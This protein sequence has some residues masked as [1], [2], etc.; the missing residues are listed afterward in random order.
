VFLD[1]WPQVGTLVLLAESSN[2]DITEAVTALTT[3]IPL[4]PNA[5]T[6][7]T[8]DTAS[9]SPTSSKPPSP[10]SST[11]H[12]A[13]QWVHNKL[14]MYN[15]SF[16]EPSVALLWRFSVLRDWRTYGEPSARVVDI[17]H[18][19]PSLPAL[20]ELTLQGTNVRLARMAP[21]LPPLVPPASEHDV[22]PTSIPTGGHHATSS[23]GSGAAI[24][25]SSLASLINDRSD[26]KRT[27]LATSIAD[28]IS[29]LPLP[30]QRQYMAS[31]PPSPALPSL[32]HPP[33]SSLTNIPLSSLLPEV[34]FVPLQLNLRY[35]E[36]TASPETHY[37][38][39]ELLRA[40]RL[41]LRGFC[42]HQCTPEILESIV[43][44]DSTVPIHAFDMKL[45]KMQNWTVEHVS[46]WH[47]ALMRL[48][49]MFA[50]RLTPQ[51]PFTEAARAF[52]KTQKYGRR[53]TMIHTE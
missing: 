18:W 30:P 51:G 4:P 8:T 17:E 47:H 26:S 10:S 14:T 20:T 34:P 15:G 12:T 5:T 27:S 23:G 29:A 21:P 35:I 33:S 3:M 50:V 19:I 53:I 40:T 49:E 22:I 6:A 2:D 44:D 28:E 45:Y 39:L 11:T 48:P 43:N 41:S 9:T 31:A 38:I 13:T 24:S 25:L 32:P 46:L 42:L 16:F 37:V 1:Q 7:T 52:M 36:L